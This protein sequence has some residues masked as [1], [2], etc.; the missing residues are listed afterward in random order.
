MSAQVRQPGR[1]KATVGPVHH[2]PKSHFLEG[3]MP[4]TSQKLSGRHQARMHS[5]NRAAAHMECPEL[6]CAM[7]WLWGHGQAT[8]VRMHA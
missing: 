8:L 5:Y 7:L 6:R 4:E 1:S 2:P 3:H